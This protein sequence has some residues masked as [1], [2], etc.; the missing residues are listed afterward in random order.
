MTRDLQ[1]SSL[2]YEWLLTG[3]YIAYILFGMTLALVQM[4]SNCPCTYANQN[5]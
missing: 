4:E 5:G 2:Q 3:F 1:L